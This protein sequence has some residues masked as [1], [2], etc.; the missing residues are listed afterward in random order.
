M[1]KEIGEGVCEFHIFD[2]GDYENAKPPELKNSYYHRWGFK[3]QDGN[4][5]SRMGSKK[6]IDIDKFLSLQDTIKQLGHDKLDVIDVFV[7]NNELPVQPTTDLTH[8]FI[9]PAL[10]KKIDCEK[11]E[12]DTYQDWIADDVPML[13]QIL[14][15]VHEAPIDKALNF[16]NLI[17]NAGY[18]RFHKEPN[19]QV[20]VSSC[21]NHNILRE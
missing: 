12:W 11:C 13:H 14:V 9:F 17:E 21:L 4:S 18:L 16:F 20:R 3:G 6:S 15:E 10:K 2:M 19:I 1:Q 7:S 8:N 5:P